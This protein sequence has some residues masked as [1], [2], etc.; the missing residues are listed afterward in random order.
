MNV[1]SSSSSSSSS[2]FLQERFQELRLHAEDVLLQMDSEVRDEQITPK[3]FRAGLRRLGIQVSDYEHKTLFE[4]FDRDGNGTIDLAELC[5]MFQV[6]YRRKDG[7]DGAKRILLQK[8][9]ERRSAT[10]RSGGSRAEQVRSEGAGGGSARGESPLSH[11]S[12]R[13]DVERGA[14]GSESRGSGYDGAHRR[15]EW[16]H[17][18]DDE[19]DGRGRGSRTSSREGR[20][21]TD[22]RAREGL[23]DS[24]GGVR[25]GVDRNL[26]G[27]G[28]E[29][30]GGRSDGREGRERGGERAS[31]DEA[32]SGRLSARHRNFGSAL[33]S[34]QAVAGARVRDDKGRPPLDL[35]RR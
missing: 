16:G 4:V 12:G 32:L 22:E 14:R 11:R 9:E 21:K 8:L 6:D 27:D 18:D 28:R 25:R 35:R 29:G 1:S 31:R 23:A 13:E 34:G 2:S 20:S 19:A 17:V 3:E 5:Y 10:P 26:A 30:S 7:G 15:A 33:S 24:R